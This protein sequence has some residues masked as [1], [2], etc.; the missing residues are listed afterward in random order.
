[1][2]RKP[3]Q[4]F[5]QRRHTMANMHM[6]RCLTSLAIREMQTKTTVR[7]HL[8]LVRMPIIKRSTNNKSWRVCGEKGTLLNCHWECKLV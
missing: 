8:T 3:K 1:M 7:Y 2:D 6:K 5:L 4:I